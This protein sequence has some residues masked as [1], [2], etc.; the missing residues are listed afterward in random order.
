MASEFGVRAA[1]FWGLTLAELDAIVRAGAKSRTILAWRTAY[2]HRVKD[3]PDLA[4]E[5]A[6]FDRGT[7]GEEVD[8][9]GLMT[10]TRAARIKQQ[11]RLGLSAWNAKLAKG[12]S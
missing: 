7:P 9:E 11:I 1:D 6:E 2:Y 12:T 10:E 5:V 4:D 3:M 8:D